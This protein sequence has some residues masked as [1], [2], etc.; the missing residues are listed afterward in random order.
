MIILFKYC[1]DVENCESFKGFSYIYI[2]IYI[3]FKYCADVKNCES[4][5][6]FDYIYIDE[7]LL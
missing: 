7:L 2:Y 1:A 5:K 6:D 4:F 3:L